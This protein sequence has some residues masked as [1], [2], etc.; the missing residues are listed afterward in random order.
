MDL[1]TDQSIGFNASAGDLRDPVL[2]DNQVDNFHFDG[3]YRASSGGVSW[4]FRFGDHAFSGGTTQFTFLNWAN[5]NRPA[6]GGPM[7]FSVVRKDIPQTGSIELSTV[8]DSITWGCRGE[9]FR[10]RLALRNPD[11]RFMGYRTDTYGYGHE[12]EGG[13]DTRKVLARMGR[14]VPSGNY[15]LLIGT[16]DRFPEEE[17]VRN[18]VLIVSELLKKKAGNRVYLMTILPRSDAI[19]ERNLR[20]NQQLRDWVAQTGSDRIRLIDAETGFRNLPDWRGLLTDGLH[21][22]DEG[23]WHL[24]EII[25]RGGP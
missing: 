7:E 24:T 25:F 21:P 6:A 14:I 9:S 19:D 5:N 3:L 11:L 13:D 20:V 18:I 4:Y 17:T 8:G 2:Y 15:L 22:S 12:G 1:V 16:N 23:Y 10:K